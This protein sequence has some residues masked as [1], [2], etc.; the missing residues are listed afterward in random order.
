MKAPTRGAV[1]T[2]A[3]RK[4]QGSDMSIGELSRRTGI[5][6]IQLS[7]ILRGLI[8]TVSVEHAIALSKATGGVV[9]VEAFAQESIRDAS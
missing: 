9:P 8:K 5:D 7:R 6:R 2:E 4:A 1:E 3:W